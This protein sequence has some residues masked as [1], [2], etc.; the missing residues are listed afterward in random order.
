[1]DEST[2]DQLRSAVVIDGHLE[3]ASANTLEPELRSVA[4]YNF[5]PGIA[6]RA[7]ASESP[8]EK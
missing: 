2:L 5:A 3:P 8:D 4:K 1:M 7:R 6:A